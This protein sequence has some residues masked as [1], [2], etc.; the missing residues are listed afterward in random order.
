MAKKPIEATTPAKKP[1]KK[2]AAAKAPAGKA[3]VTDK[4]KV[5]TT[6]AKK[7]SKTAS[8]DKTRAKKAAVKAGNDAAIK[9]L[10]VKAEPEKKEAPSRKKTPEETVA[11]KKPSV[12]RVTLIKAPESGQETVAPSVARQTS[13][14]EA[15]TGDHGQSGKRNKR[16]RNK[17]GNSGQGE[18]ANSQDVPA[19]E[20][21]QKKLCKKAWEIFSA[22]VGE[23][24]LAL[25]DDNISREAARRSFRVAEL[26]LQEENRRKQAIKQAPQQKELPRQEE[27]QEQD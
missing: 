9:A 21:N 26:F 1:V 3:A 5:K 6:V 23:E 20:L 25:M 7:P 14:Q 24:G 27:K 4:A 15:P 18:H 19:R 12:R 10:A 8:A 22:E 11:V 13:A 2:A 16:R 17:R